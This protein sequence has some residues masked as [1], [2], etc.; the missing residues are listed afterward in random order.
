MPRRPVRRGGAARPTSEPAPLEFSTEA[1]QAL[2]TRVAEGT[3]QR[4]RRR[5]RPCEACP[6]RNSAS[7]A[8]TTTAPS[9]RAFPRSSSAQGKSPAQVA[10]IVASL[11]EPFAASCWAHARPPSTTRRPAPRE[12]PPARPRLGRT[13]WVDRDPDRPRWP[14]IALVAAGTSDLPVA[15]E[16][17][18]TL[19]LLGHDP[20]A[21]LRRR[22]RRP[23]PAGSPHARPAAGRRGDRHRRHGGR[24]AQRDRRTG[25]RRRSSRCRPA[26]GTAPASAG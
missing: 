21:H 9:A 2:L 18:R 16:A 14:G 19:D 7:P 20:R 10:E 8:S 3:R 15:E 6:S 22:R 13:I 24:A 5:K 17:A 26:S 25:R 4:R 1:I 23:A 12:G 11:A